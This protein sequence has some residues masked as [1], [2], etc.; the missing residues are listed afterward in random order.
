MELQDVTMRGV[1]TQLRFDPSHRFPDVR[2]RLI[3][4]LREL[5][6]ELTEWSWGDAAEV[7]R[8]DGSLALLVAAREVRVQS[9]ALRTSD[10]FRSIAL[11]GFSR[12]LDTLGVANVTFVGIR[13][14]WIGAVDS[15]DELH[16]WLNQA[17]SAPAAPLLEIFGGP[18]SDTGWVW[19]FHQRDPKHSIRLGSMTRS[20]LAGTFVGSDLAEQY[21]LEFLFFDLDRVM[22]DTPISVEDLEA[23]WNESFDGAAELGRTLATYFQ[24]AA[25]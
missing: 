20:Q 17:L 18:P 7:H 19:E 6:E 1:T 24:R 11:G 16:E 13:S 8:S 22:S 21:P 23:R 2:G 9:H 5:D 10:D 12:A 3:E 14:F 25:E 4:Q 15:F